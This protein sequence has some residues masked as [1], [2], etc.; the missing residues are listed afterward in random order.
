[1]IANPVCGAVFETYTDHNIIKQL[2]R[3][4]SSFTLYHWR[5]AGGAEVDVVIDINAG[6]VS[7][8][9]GESLWAIP[10]TAM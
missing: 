2:S 7:Y 6:S 5:S 3:F 4:M 10:W 1:M 8:K 9:L